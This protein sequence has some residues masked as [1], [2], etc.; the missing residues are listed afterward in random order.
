MTNIANFRDK[1]NPN[2]GSHIKI[3]INVISTE[4]KRNGENSSFDNIEIRR[5]LSYARDDKSKLTNDDFCS[6]LLLSIF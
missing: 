3:I 6:G 2:C 5:S 4:V 1:E